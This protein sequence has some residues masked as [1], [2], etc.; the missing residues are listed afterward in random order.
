MRTAFVNTLVKIM[1][2]D[3]RV[4][5]VTADMGFS[6][7][8]ELQ[9]EFPKRFINTGVTEQ[10]SVSF[11]TGLAL[12]G[13][14]VFF[15][16]QAP[17]ATMRCFEQVRLDVA[18]NNMDVKIVGVSSGFY[19]NQLGVSHFATEDIALMRLLP[20]MTVFSPGDPSEA[21]F[22]TKALYKL[23]TPAYLRLTKAGSP[24][25]HIKKTE[26]NVGEAVRLTNGQDISLFATGSM[27]SY[28]VEVQRKLKKQGIKAGLFSFPTIK[29]LDINTVVRESK[30]IGKIAVIEEHTIIGG[31]GSAVAEI[32]A[33]KGLNTKLLRLGIPDSFTSVTGSQPFL[34]DYNGLS[35]EKMIAKIRKFVQI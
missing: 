3:E 35:V 4:V 17:F 21:E 13:Y 29:P 7:Y 8:E 20:N 24:I 30:K 25:V 10:S 11:A 28:A 14:K 34:L 22:A 15:Y 12:S 26:F 27:L 31:L 16:A 19:S 33:E 1:R 2:K 5:L 9:K 23:K 32:I 18:Y 6:V